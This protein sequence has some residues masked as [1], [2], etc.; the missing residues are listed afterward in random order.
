LTL[1]FALSGH[2][3]ANAAPAGPEVEL[4]HAAP[5]RIAVSSVVA[6]P[7]MHPAYLADGDLTTAWNSRS[8]D[9]AGAWIAFRVPAAAHVSKIRLTAGFT[10]NGPEGDYFLLNHRVRRIRVVHGGASSTHELDLSNRGL[11]DVPIDAEGG[12]YRIE[13]VELAPGSRK[14]W[15]ESCVSEIEVWGVL[16]GATPGTSSPSVALGSLDAPPVIDRALEAVPVG[17][18]A[19]IAAYCAQRAAR[20]KP[21][22]ITNPPACGAPAKGPTLAPLPAGWTS[23][24]YFLTPWGRTEPDC[25]LAIVSGGR[26]HVIEDIGTTGCGAGSAL[27]SFCDPTRQSFRLD[28]DRVA[29]VTS[30]PEPA[31]AD[32]LRFEVREE[33]RVCGPGPAK[34]IACT[35]PIS[36]GHKMCRGYGDG[37][38][39]A[40][41]LAVEVERW[42]IDVRL[43]HGLLDLRS[44]EGTLDAEARASLG[45]YRLSF[46]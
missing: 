6:N 7:A 3:A 8:G 13:L 40:D 10:A 18:H 25:N 14:R 21:S 17:D 2:R 46:E 45:R 22:T 43:A 28:G 19:S 9:L 30:I 27:A 36:I 41:G 20:E 5:A 31:P 38:P 16:A 1:A 23:V 11:Q 42:S 39:G 35:A 44:G 26:V 4:L 37:P 33:L 32:A 12:D 24:S 15:R 34:A 29:M